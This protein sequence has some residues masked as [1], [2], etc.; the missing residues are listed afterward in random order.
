M[1]TTYE[2]LKCLLAIFVFFAITC[3]VTC[4]VVNAQAKPVYTA[5]QTALLDALILVE[6]GGKDDAIGDNG[7]A[8]GCLQIWKCYWQDATE[9]SGIGG[10]YVDCMDRDYAKSIVDAYMKRYAKAAWT[11][12]NLFNAETCARIHNGGPKGYLKES[13]KKYWKKVQK[14]LAIL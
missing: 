14:V 11:D 5:Q 2:L 4:G 12:P 9:R 6:S 7:K 13:T 10:S 8:I 3:V 1:K